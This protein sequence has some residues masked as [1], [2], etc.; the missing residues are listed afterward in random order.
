MSGIPS[1]NPAFDRM[2]RQLVNL[3]ILRLEME[4]LDGRIER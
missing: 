4:P 2:L 1:S 3:G